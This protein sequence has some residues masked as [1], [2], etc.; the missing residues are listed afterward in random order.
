VIQEAPGDA[1]DPR[2]GEAGEADSER[3]AERAG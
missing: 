2:S 1:D 3:S